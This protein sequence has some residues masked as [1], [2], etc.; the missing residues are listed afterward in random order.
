MLE[1]QLRMCATE[2]AIAKE[3]ISKMAA[4]NQFFSKS[5][6]CVNFRAKHYA[7]DLLQSTKERKM[8]ILVCEKPCAL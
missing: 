7:I 5:M 6:K 2:P 3:P 1:Q 4:P 8:T